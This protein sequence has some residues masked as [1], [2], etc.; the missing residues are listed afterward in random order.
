M[1][2]YLSVSTMRKQRMTFRQEA[3]AKHATLLDQEVKFQL[4]WNGVKVDQLSSA[5]TDQF[6]RLIILLTKGTNVY[7]LG[8]PIIKN[9]KGST[10]AVAIYEA[11]Y[12]ND[13]PQR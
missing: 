8:F 4:H 2:Y 3:E 6:E 9:K 13:L 11:F 10:Q 5:C 1:I 7:L 12:T